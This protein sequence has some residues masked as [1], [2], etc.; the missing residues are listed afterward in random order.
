MP[1][2][3]QAVQIQLHVYNIAAD[4]NVSI[5]SIFYEITNFCLSD[6]D[7][8]FLSVYTITVELN[9]QYLLWQ[10]I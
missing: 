8:I 9:H 10:A 5:Q 1:Q 2:R 7:A 3:L 4:N 6:D